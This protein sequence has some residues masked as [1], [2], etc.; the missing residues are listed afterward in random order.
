MK[1]MVFDCPFLMEHMIETIWTIDMEALK[2]VE[3][4][5]L[6]SMGG[7]ML[8]NKG[9]VHKSRCFH[10]EEEALKELHAKLEDALSLNQR[11]RQRLLRQRR[12][13]A[14]RLLELTPS[15]EFPP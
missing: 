13:L 6:E 4:E 10:T 11:E 2:V 12:Q 1:G 14:K 3:L 8:T 9:L 5:A 15:I 7:F